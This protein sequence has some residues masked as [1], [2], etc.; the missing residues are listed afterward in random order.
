MKKQKVK[1]NNKG[2]YVTH[3]GKRIYL[4][5]V[6]RDDSSETERAKLSEKHNSHINDV[7]IGYYSNNYKIYILGY[8]DDGDAVGMVEFIGL[9]KA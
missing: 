1:Y 6:I 9:K 4:H 7:A 3:Y 5:E 8:D 2:A